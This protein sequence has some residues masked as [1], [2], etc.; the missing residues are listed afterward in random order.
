MALTITN[1]GVATNNAANTSFVVNTT[2]NCTAGATI[3]ICIA[4]DNSSSGGSTNDITNVTDALGNQWQVVPSTAVVFDNGAASAGVQGSIWFTH[5]NAGAIQTTTN[6]TVSTGST[7]T[8]KTVTFTEVTAATGF[9]A[10]IKAGGAKAAGATATAATSGA[11]GTIVV[12]QALV[13]GI[14]IE[15]GTTQTCTGDSDTTNGSW[16]TLQYTEIGTTT[17][18]SCI[19]SQG[20]VQTTADSTQSYDVTLGISSDY[21]SSWAVLVETPNNACGCNGS[22]GWW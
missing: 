16:S 19:A 18:G 11:T 12:G 13:V 5:Q 10:R 1:R 7:C 6:V 9:Q 21:H 3:L 17:S 8:A 15:A 22:M 20:K 14:Y 4:A 2:S